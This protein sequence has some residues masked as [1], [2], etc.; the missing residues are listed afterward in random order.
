MIIQVFFKFH[1]FSMH[2][3]FFLLIFQVIHDFQSLWEPCLLFTGILLLPQSHRTIG[4][5]TDKKF[6]FVCMPVSFVSY[7]DF[8]GVCCVK[9]IGVC[10]IRWHFPTDSMDQVIRYLSVYPEIAQSLYVMSKNSSVT[11][12]CPIFVQFISGDVK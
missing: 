10:S 5:A 7:T 9:S 6:K 8:L 12:M 3:A 4:H 1:D 11:Y 2:G